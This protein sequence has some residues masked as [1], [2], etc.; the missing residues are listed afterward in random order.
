MTSIS[1]AAENGFMIRFSEHISPDLPPFIQS[2]CQELNTQLEENLIDLIPS[3]TTLL[4]IYDLTRLSPTVCE[5]KIQTA[6]KSAQLNQLSIQATT[7]YIPVCYDIRLGLDLPTLAETKNLSIKKLVELHCEPTYQ[8]Y[9]TGFSPAFAY[10][11]EV[12]PALAAPRHAKPRLKI[13]AGSVGI[14][15]T[16]TAIYPIETA[17][18]WQIIGQTPLDLSLR[19]PSNLTRFKVGDQVRFEP[20]DLNTFK[21]MAAKS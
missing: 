15:D 4:V 10:L 8:V 11:G 21:Q 19:D 17:A 3:Y 20:V 14:A 2:V 13:P 5:K 6:L 16:Q 1:P 18:G 12:L 9:A 7:H